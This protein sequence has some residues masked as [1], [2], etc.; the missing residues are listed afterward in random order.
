MGYQE[1]TPAAIVF[2]VTCLL[3]DTENNTD[4]KAFKLWKMKVSLS[5]S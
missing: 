4:E 2:Q 5:L 3:K 1:D